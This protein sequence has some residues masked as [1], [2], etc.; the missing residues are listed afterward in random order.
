[1]NIQELIDRSHATAIDKGWWPNGPSGRTPIEQVN[2]FQAELSEAWEEYRKGRLSTYC[3]DKDGFP[4]DWHDGATGKPEGFWIEIS[5]F[6][7]RLA[8]TMG[9]YG[10]KHDGLPSA[11]PVAYLPNLDR[12]IFGLQAIT[13]NLIDPADDSWVK[14][15][16]EG[17][18]VLISAC[19]EAA[20]YH[21][22]DLLDL[23]KI[24]MDYNDTRPHRH[25]GKLA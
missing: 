16:S 22:I 7:I 9:A 6:C 10:W 14:N 21:G 2:N 17:A 12:L 8:D 5:D 1:M 23:C 25:G 20:Q 11:V 15:A 24:K 4:F 18:S 13:C 19:I 3:I